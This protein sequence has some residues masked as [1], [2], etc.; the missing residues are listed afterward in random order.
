MMK[1]FLSSVALIDFYK[2]VNSMPT[3][4][5]KAGTV[6]LLG[7]INAKWGGMYISKD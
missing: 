7:K 5:L 4:D 3:E 6:I 1:D 2:G